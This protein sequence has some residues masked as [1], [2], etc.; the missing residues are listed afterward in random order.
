MEQ[1]VREIIAKE[2][3]C[4]VEEVTHE[5]NLRT[6]LNMDSLDEMTIIIEMENEFEIEIKEEF[7]GNIKT[8]KEFVAIVENI[9]N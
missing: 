8:L 3:L 1:K 6:D 4:N 5:K 2:L 7:Y 9:K